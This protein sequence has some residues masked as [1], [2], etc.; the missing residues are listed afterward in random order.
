MRTMLLCLIINNKWK[1]E[2]I[3]R[4][5]YTKLLQQ[6][7]L[8]FQSSPRRDTNY[9]RVMTYPSDLYRKYDDIAVRSERTHADKLAKLCEASNH[10]VNIRLTLVVEEALIWPSKLANPLE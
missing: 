1:L 10:H 5:L 4:Y 3:V 7:I 9:V 8:I 2:S 6:K